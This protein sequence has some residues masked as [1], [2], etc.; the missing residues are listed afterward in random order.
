MLNIESMKAASGA[1]NSDMYKT[2]RA[3]HLVAKRAAWK[4]YHFLDSVGVNLEIP[5]NG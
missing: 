4:K 5:R 3:I 1:L 2:Y